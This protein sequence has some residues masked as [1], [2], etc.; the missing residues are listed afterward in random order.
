MPSPHAILLI[1]VTIAA[2]WLYTRPWIRL[3][4]VSLLLLVTLLL[5]FYV[6]PFD[7]A[8][9]R[10]TEVEIFQSFGHPALVAICSLMI[11]ARGL[12]MTGAMEPVVR[13]LARLWRINRWLGLLC[14][15][16]FAMGASAFINDTPVMVLMLPLLLGLS[17]RTNYPASKTLMPVNCAVLAGGML[18]SIGTSTNVLVLRIAEDLG[19]PRM[20]LFDF[21]TTAFIACAL[22]LPYLWLVAPH[23]LPDTGTTQNRSNRL[24]EARAVVGLGRGKLRGRKLGELARALGRA[25]PAFGLVRDG[26]EVPLDDATALA[27]GDTLLLRDTPEGL[28]EF[29]VTF[30]VDLYDR[31]GAGSFIESNASRAGIALAEVVIGAESDLHGRTLRDAGFTQQHEV[32]VVGLNRGMG[33]LLRNVTDI[34]GTELAAGDVLLVQGTADRIER[35]RG[36]H[37]LMLLDASLAV[38]HSALA[39]LALAIMGSVL[40]VAALQLLPIHVAAFLGV[41]AM[42]LTGCVRFENIGRAL[43][44]EVV[45]IIASSVALGQSLVATGAAGWV[46]QGIAAIVQPIPPAAQIAVFMAFAAVV[47]NFV[48]NAAT[49]SVGTPIAVATA[50]QL[51][52]PLEPFVLAILFGANLSYATP[53]AYQTNLLIMN[54]VGYRF[55]DF[56]RVGVPLVILMLIA[57]SVLLAKRYGL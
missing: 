31:S 8:D 2:F 46:A 9:A 53:M 6:F 32:V 16:V 44:L 25:L 45:L 4:L 42:L 55:A 3:E 48:S 17:A 40:L 26:D 21:T 5:I 38:A 51:G 34:G 23:L 22:A 14:T 39:P 47:T 57:L 54:A 18:T 27:V 29:A 11:L 20:G 35:L 28:R 13:Q 19:M 10:L 15:L 1:T 52:L 12:T 37:D 56:V 49:A 50:V 43:S 41:I 33:A 30:A 24:Y 7:G 36:R